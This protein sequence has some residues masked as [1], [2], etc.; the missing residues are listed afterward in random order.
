[1]NIHGQQLPNSKSVPAL[2]NV[3]NSKFTHNHFPFMRQNNEKF[4]N[5]ITFSVHPQFH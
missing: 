1:M 5:E 2:H 4:A 3:G